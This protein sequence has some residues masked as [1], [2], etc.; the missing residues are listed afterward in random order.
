MFFEK[1]FGKKT[2]EVPLTSQIHK[3]SIVTI[4]E[5]ERLRFRVG[6]IC[7][8]GMGI[9]YQLFPLDNRF[10]TKAAKTFLEGADKHSFER[11]AE[12]WFLIGEHPYIAKPMWF[13]VWQGKCCI[14]MD[15]YER[16]LSDLDVQRLKTEQVLHTF[17]GIVNGLSYAYNRIGLIHQDIKPPNILIDKEGDPRIADFGI[18]VINPRT[19]FSGGFAS[20]RNDAKA[21]ISNGEIGGTP[22]YMAPELLLGQAKPSVLTDIY[23]LGVTIYEW[24]T[25]EHPFLGSETGFEFLPKLREQP[26]LQ[27][28]QHFGSSIKPLI[29]IVVASLELSPEK[30]PSAYSD[31]SHIFPNFIMKNIPEKYHSAQEIHKLVLIYRT[32]GEFDKAKHLLN[33]ALRLYPDDPLLLNTYARLLLMS[34][35]FDKATQLFKQGLISLRETNGLYSGKPYL[36]PAMNYAKLLI[37]SQGYDEAQN[38]LGDCWKW[39]ERAKMKGF[40][41]MRNLLGIFCQLGIPRMLLISCYTYQKLANLVITHYVGTPFHCF[42]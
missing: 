3:G 15:W 32:Q 27:I 5:C 12:N 11:E 10:S 42:G 22:F 4:E 16:K 25:R 9:V 30:R 17:A 20:I 39:A 36:D 26:L 29:E 37:V 7:K 34:N 31:I 14:L 35:E 24:L 23:S 41:N 2:K 6:S 13:G 40:W 1:L 19:S 33:S 8:G 28:R 18:A 21:T 38:I